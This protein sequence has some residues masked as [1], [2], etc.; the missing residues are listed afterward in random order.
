MGERLTIAVAGIAVIILF[1]YIF[2]TI[3]NGRY[4]DFETSTASLS[5]GKDVIMQ[6]NGANMLMDVEQYIAGVLPGLVSPDSDENMIEA[7]AV[8]VRTK[9]YYELGSE[10]VISASDLEFTYYTKDD[11]IDRWG[12]TRYRHIRSVYD[13]A[14]INT[15]G[16]IIE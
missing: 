11:I 15:A 7:Q 4:G 14:V 8:A 3:V 16:K 2:T 10:T 5:S 1:P 6:I 9:I 13:N 12:E